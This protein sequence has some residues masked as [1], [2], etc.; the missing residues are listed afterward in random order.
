P[1]A[2]VPEDS[3]GDGPLPPRNP[4]ALPLRRA[5]ASRRAPP[6]HRRLDGS[7]ADGKEERRL[8]DA[9]G[10]RGRMGGTG[11]MVIAPRIVTLVGHGLQALPIVPQQLTTLGTAWPSPT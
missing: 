11:G 4:R 2:E 6:A 3:D 5:V 7:V 8:R 10:G 1:R 9:V